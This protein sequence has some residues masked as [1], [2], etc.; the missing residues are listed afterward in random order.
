MVF[1]TPNAAVD[2]IE[3]RNVIGPLIRSEKRSVDT[4]RYNDTAVIK[5]ACALDIPLKHIIDR[6]YE[7]S[8]KKRWEYESFRYN[9]SHTILTCCSIRCVVFLLMKYSPWSKRSSI[10]EWNHKPKQESML[11]VKKNTSVIQ[12]VADK[13]QKCKGQQPAIRWHIFCHI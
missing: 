2:M 10:S 5:I 12:K 6:Q 4:T 3:L 1:S 8:E 7:D 9:S 11:F 13:V